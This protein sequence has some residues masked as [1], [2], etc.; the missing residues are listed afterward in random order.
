MQLM[1]NRRRFLASAT[2]AVVAS[3][4]GAVES[5]AA[6]APLETSTIR[7]AKIRGICIAPQYVAEEL[8]RLDGFTDIR[9]VMAEAGYAQAEQIARGDVDFSLNFAA[10]LALAIDAGEPITLLAGVHSGCFELFGNESIRGI[11][12]LKGKTVGIQGLGSTPH[13]FVTSMAAYVGLD[14][15][16]DIRWVTNPS[17]RPMELFENG[18]VDAFLGFPPEPQ[19]LRARNIGHVVVNSAIDHPWSQYF[20]CML[21]GNANFVRNN[22][23]ATKRVLRAILKAAD[24]CVAEPRRVARQIVDG[25]FTANYDYALQTMSE[26]PYGKWRDY[27]PEDTIRFYSLRLHESGMLKSSPQKII[28]GGTDWRFLNEVKRKLKM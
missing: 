23:V 19:E 6:E 14:P 27:D 2:S 4:G 8:L 15:Q 20:C 13:V 28:A 1:L 7:L 21:A 16:R 5:L 11:T 24:L 9:Y 22:P 25:G 12:D 17:V 10:P 26:V 3:L 18:K